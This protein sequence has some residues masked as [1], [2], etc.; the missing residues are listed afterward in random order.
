MPPT[1]DL[2]HSPGMCPRLGI[3]PATLQFTG[4]H[5]T[6]EPH[7][8]GLLLCFFKQKISEMFSRT[9]LQKNGHWLL[10]WS[11]FFFPQTHQSV[12]ETYR[13]IYV[14]RNSWE[15]VFGILTSHTQISKINIGNVEMR[16]EVLTY[17]Q[18]ASLIARASSFPLPYESASKPERSSSGEDLAGPVVAP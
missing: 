12:R 8:P 3:E 2:A 17:L 13:I 14:F 16:F 5:S 4:Q 9:L 10:S 18:S 1:G 6:T 7:Q 11:I 15:F